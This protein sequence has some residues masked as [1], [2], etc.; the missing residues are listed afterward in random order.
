MFRN[1]K[2]HAAGWLIEQLGLKGYQ[3]GSAQIALRHANFILNC[4][5]GKASDIL[6]LIRHVQE[7]VEQSF[8][9]S[10]EPEVKIMGEF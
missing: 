7:Q 1:P 6:R 8:S 2:P 3:I 5:N 4:G 9:V 10:L